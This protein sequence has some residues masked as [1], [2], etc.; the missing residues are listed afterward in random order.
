AS[1]VY[2][3]TSMLREI[4]ASNKAGTLGGKTYTLHLSNDGLKII[5][6]PGYAIPADVKAAGDKAIADIIS[7]AVKV[8]P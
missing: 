4:I 3:W 5:Y 2:D 8:T 6:N 7:G 1:Q